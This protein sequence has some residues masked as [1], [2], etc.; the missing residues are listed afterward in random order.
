VHTLNGTAITAR[1]MLAIMEN[2]QD[3]GGSVAVPEPLWEFG[4]PRSLGAGN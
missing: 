1:S 3:E 4:A 2:F